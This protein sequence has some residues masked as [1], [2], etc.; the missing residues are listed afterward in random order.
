MALLAGQRITST[1]ENDNSARTIN[2]TAIS[3]ATSATTSNTLQVG[4]TT[5][6]MTF[7]NGRAFRLTLKGAAVGNATAIHAQYTVN[8]TTVAGMTLLDSSRIPLGTISGSYGFYFQ[9]VFVN[10]SGAD[11]T[12]VL[13]AGYRAVAGS[14][15][16]SVAI[17][18]T[19]QQPSFIMV[20][21]LGVASDYPS[22][23]SLV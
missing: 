17:G 14:G 7:R 1:R 23:S 11:I 20:E 8:R 3:A 19:G 2:Y 4:I 5:S 6:S 15:T 22:A 18:A 12:D 10:S 21:D 13:V 16:G 9:N